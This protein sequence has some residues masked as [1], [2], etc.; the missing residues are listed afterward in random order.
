V[1]ARKH[2]PPGPPDEV[3]GVRARLR[4]LRGEAGF[5]LNELMLAMVL[6]V[7]VVGAPMTFIIVS[8]NQQNAVSSRSVAAREAS[9]GLSQLTRDL[10]EA[11]LVSNSAGVNST[12]VSV[13][14][15]GGVATATFYLPN[16]GS[17]AA[18]TQVVWTCTP[19][20]SCTR[21]LGAA[22]AVPEI[23]GVTAATFTATAADGSSVTANPAFVSINIQAQ[24]TS[25]A[26]STHTRTVAGTSS[27]TLQD[28][29]ALRDYS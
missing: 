27:I 13:T 18:G 7:I 25:L 8:L 21:K 19:G 11:Q 14:N 23:T 22:T 5:S 15:V 2:G 28:G 20:A 16:A 3:R 26:D 4:G 9:V 12:P 1:S 24:V 6:A 17:T 29:V 10:R